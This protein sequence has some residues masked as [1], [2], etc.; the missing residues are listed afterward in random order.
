MPFRH[1]LLEDESHFRVFTLYSGEFDDELV[2]TLTSGSLLSDGYPKYV[3][4]SY[5]CKDASEVD[6]SL[7]LAKPDQDWDWQDNSRTIR[8]NDQP[9]KIGHNLVLALLHLRSEKC[10][11]NFWIDAICINLEDKNERSSQVCLMPTIVSQAQAVISWLGP[12]DPQ[13]SGTKQPGQDPWTW[14]KANRDRGK[15]KQLANYLEHLGS[16]D[17]THRQFIP[18]LLVGRK[19]YWSRIWALHE[20][21]HAQMVLFVHGRNVWTEMDFDS[22]MAHFGTLPIVKTLNARRHRDRKLPLEILL[23]KYHS[24]ESKNPLDMLYALISLSSDVCATATNHGQNG[25]TRISKTDTSLLH[26]AID[27]SKTSYQ[28]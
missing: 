28:A 20:L 25:I 14:M 24:Y 13:Q 18:T 2:G 6:A 1:K 23:L 15:T 9:F 26:V 16:F 12:D 21:Y 5:A 7:P 4:L 11:T 27:Y 22:H 19:A 8:I 17:S 3:F 10:A